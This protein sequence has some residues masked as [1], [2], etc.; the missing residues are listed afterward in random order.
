LEFEPVAPA[1]LQRIAEA[2]SA[3]AIEAKAWQRETGLLTDLQRLETG[4]EVDWQALRRDL[5]ECRA[6]AMCVRKFD[7]APYQLRPFLRRAHGIAE[8][9]PGSPALGEHQKGSTRV[10]EQEGLVAHQGEQRVGSR[11]PGRNAPRLS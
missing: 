3:G 11:L 5:V 7:K 6:T 2:G 1:A 9:R 8:C 4:I 10:R